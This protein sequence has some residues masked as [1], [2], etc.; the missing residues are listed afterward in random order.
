M[1]L[2]HLLGV[3][4]DQLIK[5]AFQCFQLVVTDYL[6]TL[7]SD[8]YPACVET[9]AKFGHQGLDLNIS[10]AAIGSLVNSLYCCYFEEELFS[11]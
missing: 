10:L 1:C 6:S 8:C 2:F 11:S 9:A 7:R 3:N 4:S 5:T